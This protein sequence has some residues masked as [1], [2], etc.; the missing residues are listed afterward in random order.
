MD[1]KNKEVLDEYKKH[2][3]NSNKNRIIGIKIQDTMRK[4]SD[5]CIFNFIK[6][7][8]YFLVK[9]AFERVAK[10]VKIIYNNGW[11]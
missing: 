7:Y 4:Q 3:N 6:I 9:F 10:L 1:N 5:F 2:I 11:F 8:M